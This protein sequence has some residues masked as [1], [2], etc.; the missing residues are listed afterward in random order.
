MDQDRPLSSGVAIPDWLD[1]IEEL[2]VADDPDEMA[3]IATLRL[4][5]YA[6][7]DLCGVALKESEDIFRYRWINGVSA[8]EH[9]QAKFVDTALPVEG[10]FTGQVFQSKETMYLPDYGKTSW[11]IP[12]FVEG[13][14]KSVIF[15]PIHFA[16]EPYGVLALLSLQHTDAYA[17]E[18]VR[19]VDRLGRVLGAAFREERLTRALHEKQTFLQMA[20][21]A[22]RD[23]FFVFDLEGRFLC[24]NRRLRESTGFTDEEI[25]RLRP[26]EFFHSDDR[27]RVR[28]AVEDVIRNGIGGTVARLIN[29]Q[30]KFILHDAQG[31]VMQDESGKPIGVVGTA[32]DV[33][34]QALAE[35]A[36]ASERALLAVAVD[37]LSEILM[38][39]DVD[40]QIERSNPAAEQAFMKSSD[41]LRGMRIVELF[42]PMYWPAVQAAMDHIG[43]QSEVAFNAQLRDALYVDR[44]YHFRLMAARDA[45]G[46]IFALVLSGYDCTEELHRQ[47]KLQKMAH[48]DAL[49][50]L[51]NRVYLL[52]RLKEI[53]LQEA[54]LS[55]SAVLLFVDL[56]GFKVVNDRFGHQMGDR[57]LRLIGERLRH[58]LRRADTV[59]R[60]GGDEFVV[61]L[62]ETD[63]TEISDRTARHILE[64]FAQPFNLDG[65][66]F[67]IGAS[68]GI[69]CAPENGAEAETLLLA[70]DQAMYAAKAAGRGC[71][72][73]AVTVN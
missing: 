26:Y 49:T 65:Q 22:M 38:V 71:Y 39:A 61:L 52:N 23:D 57:L 18:V 35:R 60:I 3:R 45:S 58:T 14:V 5:K 36:L 54:R 4:G 69:A 41:V 20:L 2:V 19:E 6:G 48:T 24:W 64:V 11:A 9:P 25:A 68:I 13:G 56:D 40:G 51:A 1:M 29:R 32:R 67:A 37:S 31:I 53:L 7:T 34:E 62:A 16:G 70:A 10:S 28:A 63:D 43:V 17:P 72:R 21:D 44:D 50:G 66:L 47:E 30:G 73:R 46:S 15:T 59:A 55:R 33:T 12:E 42:F 27:K 8:D